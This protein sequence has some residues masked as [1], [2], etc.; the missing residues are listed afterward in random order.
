MCLHMAH[1]LTTIQKK[2]RV[3][4]FYSTLI[5]FDYHAS[6]L[7]F[8]NFLMIFFSFILL[9]FLCCI[10]HFVSLCLIFDYCFHIFNWL[11]LCTLRS[12]FSSLFILFATNRPMIRFDSLACGKTFLG[13]A[14]LGQEFLNSYSFSI[15]SKIRLLHNSANE[16]I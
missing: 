5:S 15:V 11:V 14:A 2:K 13:N 7:N 12:T 4:L 1:L 9:I 10:F 3:H 8:F 6:L 16:P